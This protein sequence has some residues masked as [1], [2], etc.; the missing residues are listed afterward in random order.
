VA[1]QR[2][3]GARNVLEVAALLAALSLA[4]FGRALCNGFVSLDDEPY[5]TANPR[6]LGGL[7]WAG[8]RW[9]FTTTTEANWHPLTWISHMADVSLFQTSPFGHHLTSVLLH[10]VNSA[11]VLLM[12]FRLT[13]RL[14]RSATAAALFAVHPLRVESVA[15][16][17]ERKDVLCAFFGLL[18]FLAYA[19][20]AQ[21][22]S[23]GAY[24]AT[25]ALLTASLLCK[26]M[27]VTFP[28][29]ALLLDFWPL[30][31]FE[32]ESGRRLVAE[33]LPFA[34]L[35]AAFSVIALRVQAGGGAVA[36]LDLAPAARVS[37]A[38]LSYAAYL[39]QTFL[40]VSLSVLYPHPGRPS[41]AAIA[42]A[43]LLLAVS[44]AAVFLRR[45]YPYLFSGWFW[46]AIALLPV[47]G[48]VQIGW[49]AR[50]DRYTYLP[51][52]GLLMALVWGI[53][54]LSERAGVSRRLL[55]GAAA[56]AVVAL[57]LTTVRQIGNWKDSATLYA[58]GLEV[59]PANPILHIDMG[60][61]QVRR[62]RTEEG[63]A[64]FR[65]AVAIE[66]RYWYGELALGT[67]LSR[68]GEADEAVPHLARALSMRPDSV[69]AGKELD[70]ARAAAAG[71]HTG[72]AK[73]LL[74][75]GDVAAARDELRSALR[76]SPDWPP[77]AILLIAIIGGSPDASPTEAEEALTLAER[78]VEKSGGQDAGAFDALAVAQ[79][80]LGRFSEASATAGRALQLAQASHQ[81]ELARAIAGRLALYEAR[82]PYRAG[83]Q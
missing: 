71:R 50:A 47:I 39:G 44:M 40:P 82:R 6:V 42:A 79:A 3:P 76:L 53:T 75:A 27:L 46:F 26:P 4:V 62:G 77:A 78:L 17:A 29:L 49:Q 18:A 15:W 34:A 57:A 8:V 22:R 5:V 63:I 74:H 9:A 69:E 33:K 54:E 10:A 28:L 67:A 32:R 13:G 37:N 83:S 16:V 70:G 30:G 2:R 35:S 51:S 66:P 58:H 64:H 65:Q 60:I 1:R 59:T 31:R 80:Q 36:G 81:P 11:L 72:R 23:G 20:W 19:T 41:A 14:G 7:S 12:L 68:S 73:E 25:C 55:A 24:V 48:L 38:L 43:A 56:A 21:R 52:I 61:E 45:R